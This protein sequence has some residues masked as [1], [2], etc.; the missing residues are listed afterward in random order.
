MSEN[1]TAWE[2][3]GPWDENANLRLEPLLPR[4]NAA[5]NALLERYNYK[6][7]TPTAKNAAKTFLLMPFN[8]AKDI[9]CDLINDIAPHY[10][11][12]DTQD[13]ADFTFTLQQQAFQREA[14]SLD[15][16]T[17]S[18]EHSSGNT[19]HSVFNLN[20]TGGT[21]AFEFK[22]EDSTGMMAEMN[23]LLAFKSASFGLL[24]EKAGLENEN[25]LIQKTLFP[26]DAFFLKRAYTLINL[27]VW[28]FKTLV[29]GMEQSLKSA[30]VKRLSLSFYY[31]RWVYFDYDELRFM[32]APDGENPSAVWD[33]SK[34]YEQSQPVAAASEKVK[35]FPLP[36]A[37]EEENAA[38]PI[39]EWLKACYTAGIHNRCSC[40]SEDI[41][42]RIKAAMIPSRNTLAAGGQ[43]A[44]FSTFLGAEGIETP[45][46]DH[47]CAANET[48]E[49]TVGDL[50]EPT[51]A[52]TVHDRKRIYAI[53]G[54]IELKN[55]GG[56]NFIQKN[57]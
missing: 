52:G 18:F 10:S 34:T 30:F 13:K 48:F 33:I 49:Y 16:G 29:F 44:D 38:Y 12:A 50:E 46:A 9:I 37:V 27:M 8:S 14:V 5:R 20:Y 40:D 11:L 55:P 19:K 54:E 28:P 25:A 57:P 35:F 7:I 3:C 21:L 43:G 31:Y 6:A 41:P 2:N 26:L 22:L 15:T 36:D 39:Y 47:L 53:S 23:A 45:V 32:N 56:F 17:D 24:C 42:C 1:I 4:F 51:V